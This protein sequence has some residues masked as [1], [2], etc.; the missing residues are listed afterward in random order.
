MKRWG[1]WTVKHAWI[2]L[3]S[4]S[5]VTL[6]TALG[7]P[8]LR[9][10]SDVVKWL[11]PKDPVVRLFDKIGQE[12]GGTQL[13]MV[14]VESD[15]LFTPQ[16]LT[17]IR[18]LTETYRT[19]P[20]VSSVTSLTNILDIRKTPEGLEVTQLLDP[21]HLPTHPD[22]LAQLRAYVLSRDLYRGR[23]VSED[24]RITLIMA[25]L[26]Q[27]AD[28]EALARILRD[29]TQALV[30]KAPVPATLYF[31][32]IPLQMQEIT[33]IVLADLRKLVPIAALVVVIVL[34]LGFHTLRGV[35]LPLAV[36]LI[37]TLWTMGLMG[38]V[39][40]PLSIISNIT[41]VILIAVGTA[42]GIHLLARYR[43]EMGRGVP[44]D[45]AIPQALE[46]V[47]VPIL[48]AGLT[49]LAGFLSFLGSYLVPIN[50]FG[51]FTALGVAFAMLLTLTLLPAV[52][53]LLPSPSARFR[54]LE[55]GS[56]L[57]SRGLAPLERWAL[58]HR[59]WVFAG[60]VAVLLFA[61]YGLSRITTSVNMTEYFPENSGIRRSSEVLRLHFGGDLPVQLLV[62]GDLRNP[63]VLREVL[64]LEK[65]LRTVPGIH[66][67][68]SLAD[69]I[70]EMNETMN[71]RRTVPE[72]PE[73]VA[74]LL[75]MLEGQ[76][77]LTQLVRLE[78][79]QEGVIQA[80]FS[81]VATDQILHAYDAV[82]GYLSHHFSPR[83]A[84]LPLSPEMPPQVQRLL[85]QRVADEVCWDLQYHLGKSP[86]SPQSVADSLQTWMFQRVP[87]P[88]ADQQRLFH[89][90][91][92]YFLE[93][94]DVSLPEPQARRLSRALV[95]EV[96]T[97]QWNPTRLRSVLE[98]SLPPAELAQDPE[99]LEYTWETVAEM[100][101][102]ALKNAQVNAWIRRLLPIASPPP[103]LLKDL[104][105]DLW[106]LVQ[107]RVALPAAA[108]APADTV[109]SLQVQHAG[110][111][112]VYTKIHR[113]LLKSQVRSLI[114]AFLIVAFL[115]ALQLR[116]PVAGVLSTLPIL[117]VV[118][119]NFGLMGALGIPLDN[120]TMLIASI[121]IGI[122]IDYTIHMISRFR[123]ERDRAPSAR[124]ALMIS[125]QTTG[126]AILLNAV[127]VGLGFLV[128]VFASLVPLQRF[129]WMVAL[130]MATSA[131]AALTFLPA[132]ILAA[133]PV[134]QGPQS[135]ETSVNKEELP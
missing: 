95:R 70:A 78:D 75:F 69:L 125:L 114:L 116:S 88:Q 117:L 42:Y 23:L 24:G 81:E 134:F 127:T 25:R 94:A 91:L 17:L 39:G 33:E 86:Y 83:L 123:Y 89:R 35:L 122:G 108:L 29:T 16:G 100:T 84:V 71:D 76:E 68:Q 115:V 41:P 92:T 3:G 126:R 18:D 14:A 66:H 55:Q 61:G 124:E 27:D 50:H 40:V 74:N 132:L 131:T 112:P 60:A 47:G 6:V 79:Y 87:L 101:K 12:Y 2:V 64:R 102:E 130:T 72:T 62:Q 31:G 133:R 56:T 53:S 110:L 44:R 51:V 49:T 77:V 26:Q 34:F 46:E 5:L 99:I 85:C 80:R 135:R 107:D 121:A 15:S 118:A 37:A 98:R 113:N 36:V 30:R 32:G 38:W 128:L 58:D 120:A 10:E 8:R 54:T 21:Y 52:L 106:F 43:E 65:F 11:D 28:K 4:L 45:Q 48:L 57:L 90:L 103:D 1:L 109:V 22:T 63:F 105:G 129:G 7:I 73:G 93:E 82:E 104:K 59:R 13:A 67:P 20:G 97:G 119:F 19:L 111:L 9:V 96:Q